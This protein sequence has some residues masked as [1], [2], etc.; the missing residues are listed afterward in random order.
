MMCDYKCSSAQDKHAV[1]KRSRGINTWIIF[2]F[3]ILIASKLEAWM[4]EPVPEEMT[5]PPT[6]PTVYKAVLEDWLLG[7]GLSTQGRL[8]QCHLLKAICTE[9]KPEVAILKRNQFS[10]SP[11]WLPASSRFQ[12]LSACF[13]SAAHRTPAAAVC[14]PDTLHFMQCCPY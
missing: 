5:T 13:L 8:C 11:V 7:T 6:S 10:D 14:Y 3:S 2:I 4:L 12:K 9:A 1:L